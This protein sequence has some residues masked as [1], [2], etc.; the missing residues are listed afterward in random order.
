MTDYSAYSDE[1]LLENGSRDNGKLTELI[2]RY[3]KLVFA[4]A[5]SYSASAD[6][7][8]L[9]SDGMQ[10]LLGAISSYEPQKGA[11]A[12]FASV[13]INN[14]MKSTVQRSS[15]RKSRL[16]DEEI[17]EEIPDTSP[18][19]EERVIS[20]ESTEEYRKSIQMEL[21]PLERRCLEGVIAGFSYA[22]IAEELGEDRKTVDNAVM[23]A[24]TKL[25]RYFGGKQP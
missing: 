16:C 15:L 9:V 8:E 20:K 6:Y 21:T 19:P 11:F 12:A 24:R 13:C 18:S 3:M 7:E 23:R 25:R 17:I 14:R 2:S 10:A 5:H 22:Q 4:A 1:A